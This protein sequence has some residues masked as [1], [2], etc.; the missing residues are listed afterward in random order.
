LNFYKVSKS[1]RKNPS[2][3]NN[4]HGEIIDQKSSKNYPKIL[5]YACLKVFTNNPE[6]HRFLQLSIN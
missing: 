4:L 1:R 5:L 6:K 3:S 2:N